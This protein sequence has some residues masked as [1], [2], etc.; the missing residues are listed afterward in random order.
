MAKIGIKCVLYRNTGTNGSPS[1]SAVTVIAD[2]TANTTWDK[3]PA[4]SRSSRIKK[5]V[6]T[7][8]GLT[9]SG[10]MKKTPDD[11][12]YEAF[13]N[14]I[15]ADSVLDLLILDGPSTTNGVRG[16]RIDAQIFEG[17]EDQ[18]MSVGALYEAISIEPTDSV[19]EP[20]AVLV[21]GGAL[22]YAAPGGDTAVFT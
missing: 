9:F 22:T 13:M 3:G 21:T 16:W 5:S 10:T 1:W 15:I 14:A 6:K 18:G 17:T 8:L 19:N 7:M 2:L 12:N 20:K 11:A 4:D